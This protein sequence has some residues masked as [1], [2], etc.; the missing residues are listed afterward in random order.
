M[1][2]PITLLC[3]PNAGGSSAMYQRWK[4]LL[5]DWI[6]VMPL[7]LPGRGRRSSQAL[8]CD[9][10]AM[11]TRLCSEYLLLP[12][13]TY[14]LFGHSMGGLLA[15][16]MAQRLRQL[17]ESRA[18]RALLVSATAAPTRRGPLISNLDDESLIAEM[19]RQGGTPQEAFASTELMQMVLPLMRADYQVC[20]SFRADAQNRPLDIPLHVFAGRADINT[21]RQMEAW[22]AETQSAF[23][24]D[25]FEGGHF[26]LRA[27]RQERQLMC[28]LERLLASIGHDQL[29]AP[30]TDRVERTGAAIALPGQ[31][32]I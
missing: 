8:I 16:G 18:P 27:E 28:A 30:D 24:L 17:G 5:P 25:W 23:S 13:R 12:Q 14:A 10:S 1:S 7:E 32:V 20:A 11:V 15:Y 3:L 29:F 19:R 21:P 4:R 2:A 26:Y 22:R 6:S 31:Q 9:Y